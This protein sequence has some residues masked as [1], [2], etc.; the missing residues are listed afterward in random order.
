[1]KDVEFLDSGVI[2]GSKKKKAGDAKAAYRMVFLLEFRMVIPNIGW[3]SR[4]GKL[5]LRE[6]DQ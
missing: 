1:M 3:R 4:P 5:D 2:L 6:H